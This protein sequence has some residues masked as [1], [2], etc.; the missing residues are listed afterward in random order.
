MGVVWCGGDDRFEETALWLFGRERGPVAVPRRLGLP[1]PEGEA[2]LCAL[3]GVGPE[4]A[5]ELLR[6]CG[7]VAWALYALTEVPAARQVQEERDR[8]GA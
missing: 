6:A 8:G 7:S 5:R 2:I 4:R 3:P 1:L